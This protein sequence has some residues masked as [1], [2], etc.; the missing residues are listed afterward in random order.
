[1][2]R[3]RERYPDWD[4]LAPSRFATHVFM[5]QNSDIYR[6]VSGQQLISDDVD[7]EL[8]GPEPKEE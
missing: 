1:M 6:A 3:F 8:L 2:Q 7:L 4:Q 5:M